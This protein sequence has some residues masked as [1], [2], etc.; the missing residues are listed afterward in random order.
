MIEKEFFIAEAN[1]MKR[2]Y[3]KDRP[4]QI[5]GGHN[6]REDLS[7]AQRAAFG[8]AVLTYNLL[9]DGHSGLF[10]VMSHLPGVKELADKARSID[11]KTAFMRSAVEVASLDPDDL[12]RIHEALHR[13][14]ELKSYRNAMVHCRVID[15]SIG[16]G[17][18]DGPKGKR[19]EILLTEEA[20]DLLYSHFVWSERELSSACSVIMAVGRFNSLA[21]DDPRKPS[22]QQHVAV[23]RGS[24]YSNS[25]T[26]RKLRQL[27]DFPTEA[28]MK[29]ALS[30]YRRSEQAKLSE[31]MSQFKGPSKTIRI[32]LVETLVAPLEK[33]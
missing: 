1:A 32:P 5:N 31:W 3:D 19:S 15:A 13:F 10:W 26:C 20:L 17:L 25:D 22:A 14:D 30:S 18:S 11:E 4:T 33:S 28:E 29:A 16:V 27:P 7:V 9:E 6:P 21:D 2:P 8:T 24:F 23:H 12:D